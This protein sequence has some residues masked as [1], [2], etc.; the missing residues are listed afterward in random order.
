M[1]PEQHAKGVQ[2]EHKATQA[3]ATQAEEQDDLRKEK[4]VKARQIDSIEDILMRF[5]QVNQVIAAEKTREDSAVAQNRAMESV[6]EGLGQ[7]LLERDRRL[8]N[9][10]T[11]SWQATI[12][13]NFTNLRI[14]ELEIDVKALKKRV[15]DLGDDHDF[16][17]PKEQ[18][19][20]HLH[21]I[22]RSH[23]NEFV[24]NNDVVCLPTQQQPALEV[25]LPG[26]G[27]PKQRSLQALSN[28]E[29]TLNKKGYPA[30]TADEVP[31]EVTPDR[32]RIRSRPLM[33]HLEELTATPIL[34]RV[35]TDRFKDER[36]YN[37][38][39]FLRPFRFFIRHEMAIRQSVADVEIKVKKESKY[40]PE[41]R[42]D[43]EKDTY[44]QGKQGQQQFSNK[45]LLEDLRLLITFLDKDLSPTLRL[46]DA[47]KDG[48][49]VAVEYADLRHL[50]SRGD[51]VVVKADEAFARMVVNLSGGRD[52]LRDEK[53]QGQTSVDGFAIDCISLGSNG[54]SFV[55][56]L[57]KYSIR[58]FHGA[59]PISSLPIYPLKFDPN[60]QS[61]STR[62]KESGRK[63]ADTTH[64]SFSHRRV[65]GNTTDEPSINLDA[66]VIVDMT[67]AMNAKPEWRADTYV[68][69]DAFTR[70]DFREVEEIPWC[71]HMY[72]YP[73]TCCGSDA[74]FNDLQ[75]DDFEAE[76]F[77][78]VMGHMLHP[79]AHG[80]LT[81]DHLLIMRP[82][83]HAFVLRSR[84]WVTVRSED[85]QEVVFRNSFDDLVVPDNHKTTVKAL[86]TTHENARSPQS[87]S[88]TE[89]S[90]VGSAL[91]LVKGK[92]AGLV[93]LLHGPPGVGKTST[94][95]C[96]ADDTKRPLFPITCGDIG[97]TASDVEHNLQ[98]N[99][100]LAHKWGCV[101][102]LDEA[103]IFLAK[104]T[105]SDLRHNAVTS[106]FLRSL[107]YYAGI[108]FLT[109]NRVGAIDPAFR[110]R[111][112]MSLFYPKLSLDVTCQ[113]YMKFIRRAKAEQQRKGD[114]LFKIK[115]KEILKFG[116]KHFRV[117]E[118]GGYETWNGRQIRNAFQ[119]AIALSE[120]QSMVMTPGDPMPTLGKE[121]F[122]TVA[123]GFTQFDE[124]LNR[125]IG[126]TDADV[127]RR[128]G[129]RNDNFMMPGTTLSAPV[130]PPQASYQRQR[131]SKN[132]L[133]LD[134]DDETD[135]DTESDQDSGNE[136][137]QTNKRA[138][139][140][141]A[142]GGNHTAPGET[143]DDMDEFQQFKMWKQMMSQNK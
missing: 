139:G 62:F 43:S 83:V 27:A 41:K 126:G 72:D 11:R 16:E 7:D 44:K 35:S 104:R 90:S 17:I 78:K 15:Y 38:L 69:S 105:R 92:G 94:A 58:K 108:L 79:T 103:D 91:D 122:E 129:Y 32:L 133:D 118:K 25:R 132:V 60:T 77:L 89:Q 39:V 127:A 137:G 125:T 124:Y 115:E 47:F 131:L 123:R 18:F 143:L 20:I 130:P 70:K 29:T 63:F 56:R 96:V 5:A 4:V 3:P 19:P 128:E 57:E 59:R 110:S 6:F 12:H 75:L 101:L 28:E 67:L 98:K 74:I 76:D 61:L 8:G 140:K 10:N 40:E 66:E 21:E 85:L 31:V 120:H 80:E 51:I 33:S 81:D 37:S 114:P 102:L 55:P 106:V 109:T 113:L 54:S 65:V 53:K 48:T 1:S 95:E 117:L 100:Q 86:V 82:Y 22:R 46:F 136:H 116:K 142:S 87:P 42:S 24:L 134:S 34:S 2:V 45:T 97:E 119:T 50:F 49:D 23:P 138:K 93:I 30:G 107:E 141:V 9:I 14:A 112:Q 99:F 88:S 64:V 71:K 111:I 84:Q 36:V 26:G 52:P 121:Q 135:S 13:H 73:R 68:S